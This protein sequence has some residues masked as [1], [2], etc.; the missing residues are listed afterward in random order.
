MDTSPVVTL[1]RELSYFTRRLC[2][3][4]KTPESRAHFRT[5]VQ[6]QLSNLERKSVAPMALA[7]GVSPRTL[8]EFLEI[9][10]WDPDQVRYRLQQVVMQDHGDADA[11]GAGRDAALDGLMWLHVLE[12]SLN[13]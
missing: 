7:A 5:Y 4:I 12:C 13:T 10:R 8:Q 11:I 2:G 6:G 9:H 1:K 3:D